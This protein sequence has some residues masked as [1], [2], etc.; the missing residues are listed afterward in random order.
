MRMAGKHELTIRIERSEWKVLVWAFVI[1]ICLHSAFYGG[2]QAGRRFGW[3][4]NLQMP[5]WLNP[6][7]LLL[8]SHTKP[9]EQKKEEE[10]EVELPLV[11]VDVSSAQATTEKP[12]LSPYYSDKNSV[13]ANP[14][15][16]AS[17]DAPMIDGKQTEIVKTEDVPR[18]KAFPLQPASPPQRVNEEPQREIKP[19][20]AEKPGD[21]AMAKP[22]DKAIEA[23]PKKDDEPPQPPKPRT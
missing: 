23:P 9:K 5:S 18:E 12:K 4:R 19:K 22:A 13:A 2:Y 20:P 3:W 16:K 14:D 17:T 15:T 21:L 1:S 11:F 7:K 8:G 6:S 10:I